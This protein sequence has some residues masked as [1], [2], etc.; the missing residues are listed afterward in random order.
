IHTVENVSSKLQYGM[1]GVNDTSISNSATP[2]GGVKHSGFGREN[3]TY[4]V[5]EYV[6][7]KFVNIRTAK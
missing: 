7:V 4:G 3:G 1:V 2:F 5:E 6:N